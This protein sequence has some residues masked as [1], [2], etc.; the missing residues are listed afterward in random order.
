MFMPPGTGLGVI[1]GD[2][3]SSC[4]WD[5]LAVVMESAEGA[6][7]WMTT[8]KASL[9]CWPESIRACASSLLI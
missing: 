2:Q 7:P 6:R 9:M 4:A 3:A 1:F 5:G 8:K